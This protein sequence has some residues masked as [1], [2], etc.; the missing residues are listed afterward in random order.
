MTKIVKTVLW[1]LIGVMVAAVIIFFLWVVIH[2]IHS[3]FEQEKPAE[4]TVTP[5]GITETPGSNE[6]PEATEINNATEPVNESTPVP[7]EEPTPVPVTFTDI[8]VVTVGD[9]TIYRS[10]WESALIYGKGSYDFSELTKYVKPIAEKADLAIFNCEGNCAGEEFGYSDY[11]LFNAPDNILTTMKNSGFD[12]S[13]FANN[14]TYDKKHAGFIN[15]QETMKKN[16]LKVYGTRTSENEKSYGIED[17]Q[18]IKL[19][20]LN[21]TYESGPERADNDPSLK[22]LNWNELDAADIRLVDSF[23]P[24]RLDTFY[25]E[26]NARITEMKAAGAD[27]I[28]FFIHWG[29]EYKEQCTAEQKIIAQKLCDLGVNALI[30]MHPHVVEPVATYVSA[31]GSNRMICYYSLGNFVSAQNRTTFD[32]KSYAWRTE[33]ELMAK[34]TIRKYSTG[35]ALIVNAQY[36]PLWSHRHSMPVSEGSSDTR[37]VTN[38]IPLN[39]ALVDD[40]TR[41]AYGLYES[42]FGVEHSATAKE[43]IDSLVAPGIEEFNAGIVLPR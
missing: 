26:V 23:H 14:H 16:G 18:G 41:A 34:L 33:N 2:G 22:F 9:A 11:P 19:G 29:E 12:I 32:N 28:L 27:L 42:S 8:E 3:S 10:M 24:L 20:I 40:T 15:T 35:E 30:G 25:D 17:V 13:L 5:A 6:T 21:Y 43:Y 7:T 31:D 38:I 36:E 39:Y 37:V 4:K 1:S